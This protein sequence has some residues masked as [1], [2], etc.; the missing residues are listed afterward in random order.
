MS[1]DATMSRFREGHPFRP[2]GLSDEDFAQVDPFVR[3][4]LSENKRQGLL[5]AVL[6]RLGCVGHRRRM[7]AFL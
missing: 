3:E 4:A 5:L 2:G 7:A 1:I 6:R